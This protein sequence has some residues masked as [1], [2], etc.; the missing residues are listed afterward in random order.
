MPHTMAC[1][2]FDKLQNLIADGTVGLYYIIL[3]NIIILFNVQDFFFF[4]YHSS[5]IGTLGTH[6][7]L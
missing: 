3:F 2:G 4:K 6:P 1:S 5:A 7:V